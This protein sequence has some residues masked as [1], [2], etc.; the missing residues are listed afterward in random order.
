MLL[1]QTGY[2]TVRR[3]AYL[4]LWKMK[5]EGLSD[6]LRDFLGAKRGPRRNDAQLVLQ[7]ID[8]GQKKPCLA[9]SHRSRVATELM[10]ALRLKIN[11]KLI[12]GFLAEIGTQ[13]RII[14]LYNSKTKPK[15]AAAYKMG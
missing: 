11:P 3:E 8:H 13:E 15:I 14:S 7:L 10:F 4:Y 6:E 1:G 5:A 9:P 2:G 12:L